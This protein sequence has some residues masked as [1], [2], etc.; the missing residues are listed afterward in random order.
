MAKRYHRSFADV[1][2]GIYGHLAAPSAPHRI[3]MKVAGNPDVFEEAAEGTNSAPKKRKRGGR[4]PID[5][6]FVILHGVEPDHRLDRPRRFSRRE[7]GEGEM[8]HE[9][10]AATG[11]YQ[12]GGR[13]G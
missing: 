1:R 9:R 11:A 5:H 6:H 7:H 10:C 3:A 13:I 4:A 2:D 8:K 12:R